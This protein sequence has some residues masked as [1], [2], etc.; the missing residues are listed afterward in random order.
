MGKPF[1][2]FWIFVL[3]F[4]GGFGLV[5]ADDTLQKAL[6]QLKSKKVA[7]R[8]EA[9]QQLG[10]LHDKA[11][12]SALIEALSDT[13][14]YVR[15]LAVRALGYLHATEAT[16]QLVHLLQADPESEVRENVILTFPLLGA[17]DVVPALAAAIRD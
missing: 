15:V 2:W 3:C 5:K 17:T 9:A 14:A 1:R 10:V 12:A 13:D 11:A 16:P 7:Q 4:W 8:R 6:I